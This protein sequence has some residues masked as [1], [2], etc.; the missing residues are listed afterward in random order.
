MPPLPVLFTFVFIF[1]AIIGSFLN[2]VILRGEK[3]EK[4]NGRSYCP[5][6]KK[7]LA[8]YEL[9]PILSYLFQRGHCR[10]CGKKV[11]VQYPLVE[12]T[13]G[14]IFVLVVQGASHF[15]FVSSVLLLFQLAI[16]SLLIVIAVYDLRTKLIKDAYSYTFAALALGAVVFETAVTCATQCTIPTAHLLAGPLFFLPFYLLWKVSD[17]RWIGLGDG[18]LALG[19]GWFLGLSAGGTAILLAFWIGAAISLL[20]LGIQ[21]LFTNLF[22]KKY[23]TLSFK[24]E[25]PFGPFLILG[26][27]IVFF[28]G[29]DL[30]AVILF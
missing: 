29:F 18:K 14:A 12:V 8:W 19:I 28:F 2:V 20:L 15:T 26:V 1:G 5:Q 16:W 4:L 23:P 13:T 30:F 3:E 27:F 10:G 11:S 24:S 7:K 17:G 25:I 22:S 9:V 6:C 21:K